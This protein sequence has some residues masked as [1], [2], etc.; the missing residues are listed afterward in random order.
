[1]MLLAVVGVMAMVA[2]IG[3]VSM[4]GEHSADAAVGDQFVVDNLKYEVIAEGKVEVIDTEGFLS[5]VTVPSTVTDGNTDY[6]VTSIGE[7]AFQGTAVIF[8]TLPDSVTTIG[9]QAF[10]TCSI[11][12]RVDMSNGVTSIGERAFLNCPKLSSISMSDSL[13]SIGE[14]AFTGCP[15]SSISIPKSVTSIGESAFRSCTSL[16]S[17]T[18]HTTAAPEM[19]I[20]SFKT[21]S[22][23]KVYTPGWDPVIALDDVIGTTTTIV[24]ANPPYPDL[25]FIS[26]PSEGIVVFV[27]GSGT[28]IT[29]LQELLDVGG[30]DLLSAEVAG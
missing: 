30:T 23:I 27:G 18:F 9:A 14:M 22:T 25:V 3:V 28:D 2:V 1:M 10:L 12:T 13:I 6:E 17:I 21:G 16:D 19:G 11:L 29:R 4:D 15:I 5:A 8:L 7:R 24:W 20:D 26:V